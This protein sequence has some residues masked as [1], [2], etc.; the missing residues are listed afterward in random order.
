MDRETYKNVYCPPAADGQIS[1][2]PVLGGELGT[3]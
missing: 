3:V 1:C 2:G